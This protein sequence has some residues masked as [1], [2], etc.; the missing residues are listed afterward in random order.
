[1]L[2]KDEFSLADYLSWTIDTDAELEDDAGNTNV[3][4][5]VEPGSNV[6]FISDVVKS[7]KVTIEEYGRVR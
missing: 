6:L 5:L 1:M 2:F 7:F 4:T 3:T